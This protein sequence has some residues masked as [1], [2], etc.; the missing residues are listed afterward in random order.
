MEQNL[1]IEK[2]SM[3]YFEM[4]FEINTMQEQRVEFEKQINEQYKLKSNIYNLI[5]K[6]LEEKEEDAKAIGTKQE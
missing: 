6:K 3:K 4:E 1:S 2:L 5:K